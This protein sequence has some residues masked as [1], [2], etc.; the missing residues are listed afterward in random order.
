MPYRVRIGEHLYE[1]EIEDLHQRP[2][3]A[4]IG[5]STFEIWPEMVPATAASMPL[6]RGLE[7]GMQSN[8]RDRTILSPLPGTIT[9]VNVSVGSKVE[10]G[11]TLLVIEAM[12][13]KNSIRTAVPGRVVAIHVQSGQSVHHKQLLV[14]LEQ[15][16]G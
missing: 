4:R 13:M 5:D 2:V 11:E 12:K 9:Q 8:H 6:E 10:A 16:S 15:E 7:T 1:V 3:I 14:E